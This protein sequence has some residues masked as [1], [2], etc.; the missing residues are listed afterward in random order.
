[1][2]VA[3]VL[4]VL[5]QAKQPLPYFGEKLSGLKLNYSIYDREFYAIIR[6]SYPLE[7]LCQAKALCDTFGSQG[8]VFHQWTSQ[9]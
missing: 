2:L 1:M 6:G 3:F 9:A 5:N 8:L 7:S 4:V